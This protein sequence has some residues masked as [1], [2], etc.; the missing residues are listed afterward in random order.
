MLCS[1]VAFRVVALNLKER[2]SQH[3]DGV[4]QIESDHAFDNTADEPEFRKKLSEMGLPPL[5]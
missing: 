3:V 5:T 2:Y 4:M 1:A